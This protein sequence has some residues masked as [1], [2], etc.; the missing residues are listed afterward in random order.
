MY[1]WGMLGLVG[2]Q[3]QADKKMHTFCQTPQKPTWMATPQSRAA[4]ANEMAEC[5]DHQSPSA[6]Q[7]PDESF[8]ADQPGL[9]NLPSDVE[10]E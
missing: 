8:W 6:E 7:V 10:T 4:R 5:T 9:H 2:C 1:A 3:T